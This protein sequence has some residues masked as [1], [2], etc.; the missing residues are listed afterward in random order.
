MSQI[1]IVNG[2]AVE[3]QLSFAMFLAYFAAALYRVLIRW[4]GW[5]IAVKALRLAENS[6]AVMADRAIHIQKPVGI[7]GSMAIYSLPLP[8]VP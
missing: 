1:A 8:T 6:S 4:G 5:P 2:V 3:R 7:A